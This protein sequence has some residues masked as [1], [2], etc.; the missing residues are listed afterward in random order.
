MKQSI[1]IKIILKLLLIN[2]PVIK[3]RVTLVQNQ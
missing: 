1:I 2:K 3:S